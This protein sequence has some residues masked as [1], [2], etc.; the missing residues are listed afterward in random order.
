VENKLAYISDSKGGIR[1]EKN[2]DRIL[3]IENNDYWLFAIFDGVSSYPESY[4]YIEKYI[5]Y[6]D[7]NYSEYLQGEGEYLD[8]LLYNAYKRLIGYVAEGSTTISALYY[9]KTC[10]K[11]KYVNIGDSRI[12]IF[13][14]HYIEKITIDD[15]IPW[16][17]NV[18]TRCLGPGYLSIED[19]R[20]QEIEKDH[21]FLLCTDGFYAMMEEDPYRYFNVINKK[22]L[23]EIKEELSQVQKGRNYDDS[24]YIL[25]KN[26]DASK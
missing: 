14:G 3:I 20:V 9:S 8:K 16:M 24:S 26:S 17:P 6:L 4:I 10:E 12:Y 5:S 22:D 11:A 25:I 1:R 13:S 21:N 19:F 15:N 18:L 2:Q 7:K 23:D